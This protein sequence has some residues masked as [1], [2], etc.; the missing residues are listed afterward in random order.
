MKEY[1]IKEKD[2]TIKQLFFYAAYTSIS[3]SLGL[4][5]TVMLFISERA[6]GIARMGR[7]ENVYFFSEQY[8]GKRM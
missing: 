3:D 2:K 7:I 4:K 5:G 6:E 8:K 1:T